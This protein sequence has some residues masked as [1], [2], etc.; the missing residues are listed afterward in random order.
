M[1]RENDVLKNENSMLNARM[2]QIQSSVK[3]N[4]NRFGHKD[5]DEFSEEE[6]YEVEQILQHKTSKN[7]RKFLGR[8]M[9]F[10]FMGRR[11]KFELR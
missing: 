2:K 1:K 4:K 9:G 10:R 11:R 3:M 5:N 7:G 6:E 8:F